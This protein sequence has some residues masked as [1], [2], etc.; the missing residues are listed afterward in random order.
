MLNNPNGEEIDCYITIFLTM[1]YCCLYINDIES[2][3]NNSI[4]ISNNNFLCK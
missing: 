4:N 1:F 2:I 3:H